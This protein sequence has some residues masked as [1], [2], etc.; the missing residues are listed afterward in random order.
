VIPWS[1]AQARRAAC[2]GQARQI[3]SGESLAIDPGVPDHRDP[4]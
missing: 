3:R 1:T 2:A 4:V